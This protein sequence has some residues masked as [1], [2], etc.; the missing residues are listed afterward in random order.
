M[1]NF[2]ADTV[3]WQ[4]SAVK[5]GMRI[6]RQIV[7]SVETLMRRMP[8]LRTQM[9]V[10]TSGFARVK[11]THDPLTLQVFSMPQRRRRG[12]D[13]RHRTNTLPD[14]NVRDTSRRMMTSRINLQTT[15]MT[16]LNQ[17]TRMSNNGQSMG[18]TGLHPQKISD[19]RL[20]P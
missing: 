4:V 8:Y 12:R 9:T 18:T 17:T 6:R 10:F 11:P 16:T 1:Q 7:K 19:L 13:A 5:R 20:Q 3:R 2:R 15:M 14:R